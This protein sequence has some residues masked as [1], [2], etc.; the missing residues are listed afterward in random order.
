MRMPINDFIKLTTPDDLFIEEQI[1]PYIKDNKFDPLEFGYSGDTPFSFPVL[2]IDSKGQVTGHDGRG[3]SL[4]ALQDGA[5]E[6]PVILLIERGK[7][8]NLTRKL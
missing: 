8:D 7:D 5:T 2:A 1:T 4:T 6:V 3:R